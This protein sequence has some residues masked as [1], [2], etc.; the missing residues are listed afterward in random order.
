MTLLSSAFEYNKKIPSRY[1]CDGENVSPPLMI[2]GIPAGAKSLALIVD[3]PDAPA[4]TWVH[5]LVWNI[6]PQTTE[7]A[8]G[9]VPQGAM[10]GKTSFG[11]GGYGGPCPPQGEHRYFFKLYALDT[12]LALSP[13][14]DKAVLEAAMDGH[15]LK[16]A[17]LVGLYSR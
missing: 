7:I 10:E 11:R 12:T 14:A 2:G 15:I 4:G 3:D 6:D 5:W 8:E 1:T 16:K 9:S 13:K 17:E